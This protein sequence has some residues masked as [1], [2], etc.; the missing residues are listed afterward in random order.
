MI[1]KY[2]PIYCPF[3]Q[4]TEV[5]DEVWIQDEFNFIGTVGESFGLFI[6][7]SWFNDTGLL[8]EAQCNVTVKIFC[9]PF[10]VTD[11]SKIKTKQVYSTAKGARNSLSHLFGSPKHYG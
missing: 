4:N 10:A 2:L 8:Y 7:F 3:I 5:H 1:Y 11:V 9:T 6:G